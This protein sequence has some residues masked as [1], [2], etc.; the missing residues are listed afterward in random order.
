MIA[1][2]I[3]FLITIINS[4]SFWESNSYFLK[5]IIGN[6]SRILITSSMILLSGFTI[7]SNF[8]NFLSFFYFLLIANLHLLYGNIILLKSTNL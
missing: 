8:D 3:I 5:N 1:L 4:F 2:E 6:N 7:I